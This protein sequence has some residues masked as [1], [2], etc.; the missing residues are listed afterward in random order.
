MRLTRRMMLALLGGLAIP[1]A[2]GLAKPRN[3]TGQP[4]PAF[5]AVTLGGEPFDL[6]SLRGKV[7]LIN[8]WATWCG[9]CREEMP[10]LDAFYR[11]YHA[12]GLEMLGVSMDERS[13]RRQ[14]IRVA[15]DLHY[16]AATVDEVLANGFG[17]PEAVPV[18]YTVDAAGVVRDQ[19]IAVRP[20]TLERIILPLLKQAKSGDAPGRQ[21]RDLSL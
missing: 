9:P 6:A 18:N 16:P 3:W 4:A 5:A 20:G 7:V 11:R 21:E 14:V 10:A 12:Q 15:R 17:R 8:F 2:S 13:G 1:G 19:F